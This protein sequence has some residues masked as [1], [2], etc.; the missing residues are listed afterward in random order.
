VTLTIVKYPENP[1]PEATLPNNTLPI[2]I[3]VFVG[4]PDAVIWPIH[5]EVTYSDSDIIGLDENG[6]VMYYYKD[7]AWHQCRETGVYPNENIIWA[8]LFQDELTGSPLII[9]YVALPSPAEFQLSNLVVSPDQVYPME[10]VTIMFNVTNIGETT[11]NYS[12]T[13][14]VN[15]EIE[16]TWNLIVS[17]GETQIIDYILTREAVGTYTVKVDTLEN[18]FIVLGSAAFEYLLSA[19]S[20]AEAEPGETVNIEIRVT[21]VGSAAGTYTFNLLLDGE[22]VTTYTGELVE[23]SSEDIT[24]TV[25]SQTIGLHTI[26]V[27][28]HQ[29][30]FIVIS[31]AEFE[32]TIISVTPEIAEPGEEITVDIYI[33]NIGG[34][35]G[36]FDVDLTL[37][38]QNVDSY[39][40]ELISG[41]STLVFST[42]TS[43]IEGTHT[44]DIDGDTATFV[45][46]EPEEPPGPSGIQI[47]L[48][49][50]AIVIAIAVIIYYLGKTGRISI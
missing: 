5:I 22:I 37:D 42:L 9:V 19:P 33:E 31:P 23:G 32:Y 16:R 46:E 40:G 3:D 48:V 15:E 20:P 7:G 50:I 18:T 10:D 45:V 13:L 28:G 26:N 30:I 35:T 4:N 41:E 27:I 49:L 6:L 11:G 21:N 25:A 36:S 12:A 38:G 1:H 17:A 24:A 29:R 34:V 39:Q 2:F 8:N 47:N 43:E 14:S 44:I